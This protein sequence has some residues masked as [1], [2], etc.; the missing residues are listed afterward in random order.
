[1]RPACHVTYVSCVSCDL[2]VIFHVTC[3]SCDSLA[4]LEDVLPVDVCVV[5]LQVISRE[6]TAANHMSEFERSVEF[7]ETMTTRLEG[8]EE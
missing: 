8:R 6:I 7:N 4:G 3:V 5:I 1:M 2:H